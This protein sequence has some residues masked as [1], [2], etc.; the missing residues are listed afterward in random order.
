MLLAM[1]FVLGLGEHWHGENSTLAKSGAGLSPPPPLLLPPPLPCPCSWRRCAGNSRPAPEMDMGTS[2]KPQQPGWG[3]RRTRSTEG[4]GVP[5]A[6]AWGLCKNKELEKIKIRGEATQ[7]RREDRRLWDVV[8]GRRSGF[9]GERDFF[10]LLMGIV[11][12]LSYFTGGV[13]IACYPVYLLKI[14]V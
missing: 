6:S 8:Q 1:A 5:R 13:N 10:L 7:S 9:G 12:V 3:H 4:V 2:W 14:S 11:M